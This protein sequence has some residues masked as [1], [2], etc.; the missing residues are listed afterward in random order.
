MIT[1]SEYYSDADEIDETTLVSKSDSLWEKGSLTEV[2]H[3]TAS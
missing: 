1:I 3:P 2:K